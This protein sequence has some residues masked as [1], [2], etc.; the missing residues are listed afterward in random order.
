M[1]GL[2]LCSLS[3][4]VTRTVFNGN[5]N[6]KRSRTEIFNEVVM[7]KCRVLECKGFE[8]VAYDFV[9]ECWGSVPTSE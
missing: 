4:S 5:F 7:S 2:S 9:T 1:S 8:W 3:Y 6:A